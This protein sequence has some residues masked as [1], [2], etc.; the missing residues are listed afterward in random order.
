MIRKAAER[1]AKDIEDQFKNLST[2][3]GTAPKATSRTEASEK[4]LKK[5]RRIVNNEVDSDDEEDYKQEG[6]VKEIVTMDL[7]AL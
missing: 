3:I 7:R 5:V 6:I 1:K 2:V 4:L